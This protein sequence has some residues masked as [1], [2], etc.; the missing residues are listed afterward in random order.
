M[1]GTV[2]VKGEKELRRA[3]AKLG[4]AERDVAQMAGLEAGAR[5]VETCAKV[6]APVDTGALR[7]SI[8]VDEPVTRELATVSAGVEYAVF[9][10]LGTSDSAAHPFLRPALDQHEGEIVG[11][12][13]QTIRVFVTSAG[14]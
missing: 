13:A 2:R 3:L 12:V 4:G 7:N 5:I 9:Q 1:T 14:R 11:A 10:E 6:Y 8:Q